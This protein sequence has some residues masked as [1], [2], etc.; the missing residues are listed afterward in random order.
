MKNRPLTYAAA[1]NEAQEIALSRDPSVFIIGE[2]VPDP[3]GIFGT[4]LGL[5]AKFSGRVLDMP[6]SENGMTGICVGAAISG[7]HPIMVHARM[8]FTLMSFDAIVNTA[9]K[10]F[11]MF[12]G[13]QSVPIV[14]RMIIGRGWGQGPQHS[15]SLQALFAHI[16]G[17]T[18]VMPASPGDAKGLLLSAIADDHPVIFIEHRWLHGLTGD[19]P[20]GRYTVPIGKARVAREGRDLT[21]VAASY[22]TVEAVRAAEALSREGIHAEVV[23]LRSIRPLDTEA[24]I[25]S[26]AKTHRLMVADTGW[27]SFGIGA[28]IVAMVAETGVR[29]DRPPVRISLP[30]MPTP[31][32]PALARSYYPT[33]VE[34]LRSALVVCGRKDAFTTRVVKSYAATIKGSPDQPDPTFTGPF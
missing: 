29:L 11:F 25:T 1:I 4:T 5:A 10:W 23:D 3:K 13:R 14:I 33:S 15:Q 31:T 24:I 18:V 7:M 22:M 16:P 19:V 2:G 27:K 34:I 30:D 17:L 8:D 32:S 21:I 9:A 26:V 20:K 6:V 12:G 28:E